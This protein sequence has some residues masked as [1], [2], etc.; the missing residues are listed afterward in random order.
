RGDQAAAWLGI[1]L[2]LDPGDADLRLRLAHLRQ[3]SCDWTGVERLRADVVEPLLARPTLEPNAGFPLLVLPAP[4]S[5]AEQLVL[6]RRATA[7]VAVQPRAH[8]P[9][10][11]HRPLR[12]GYLS[13][14]FQTHATAHLMLGLFS[15][16]DRARVTVHA[17][18]LGADDGSPY[19]RRIAADCDAFVDL[20]PLS[21]ALAAETIAADR[22]D[23]LVDLKGTTLGARLGIAARRPA[24]V[25]VAWL[26]YPGSVGVEFLDYALTDPVVT[27]PERQAD[28]A[29]RLVLLPGSYQVNDRDQPIA[30]DAPD[31]ASA[32]LPEQGFVFCCFN[33]LYKVEPLVFGVW[34]DILRAVPGSLLWLLAGPPEAEANLRREAAA[35]GVEPARLIFAPMLPKDRHLARLRHAGLFLDTFFCNAH[36]TAS[37]A[38]W[39]GVPVLTVPGVHFPARVAASLVHAVGLPELAVPDHATYRDT[40]IALATDPARLDDLRARLAVNRLT[41]PL[42]DT[43]AF[44]RK[45]ETA[46]ETI[47][48]R[49]CRG[50]APE[51]IDLT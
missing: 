51:M 16:H 29:E 3:F 37:D 23:I 31:R 15:R 6:A 20:A 36:T 7:G 5:P 47:W 39:A 42:F 26:G 46:F 24:P 21:D 10:E 27:P 32:G 44:A 49:H 48:D 35:R 45:L 22:I 50:L 17:Y 14:D 18:S 1:A 2:A 9:G 4:I 12:I 34:M 40:A 28:W 30:L 43:D 38:L 8:P 13:A 19:R 33:Q 41:T 25:Q 11:P